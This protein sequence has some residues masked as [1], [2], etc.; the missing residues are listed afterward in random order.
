MTND[1]ISMSMDLPLAPNPRGKI[2]P[3]VFSEQQL[4]EEAIRL[5]EVIRQP[6]RWTVEHCKTIIKERKG[7]LLDSSFISNTRHSIWCSR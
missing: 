3:K 7:C 5:S 2:V 6:K 1:C 4:E